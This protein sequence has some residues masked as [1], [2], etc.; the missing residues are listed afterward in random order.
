MDPEP[1]RE[2]S[3]QQSFQVAAP[4]LVIFGFLLAFTGLGIPLLA[5]VTDRPPSSSLTPLTARDRHGSE[6]PAPLSLSRASQ[7]DR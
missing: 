3:Q 5:V 1:A 2:L 7:P 4:T 6:V